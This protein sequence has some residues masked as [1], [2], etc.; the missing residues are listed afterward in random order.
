MAATIESPRPVPF[1]AGSVGAEPVERLGERVDVVLGEDSASVLDDEEG[2]GSV[3]RGRDADPT[4]RRVVGDRIFDHVLDHARQQCLAAAYA[5]IGHRSRS[6]LSWVWEMAFEQCSIAAAATSSS[7][8][9]DSS[10]R[11][12]CC[13]RARTRKLS[14]SRST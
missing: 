9:I 5:G 2:E 3:D 14:S 8:T 4:A 7:E 11:G 6:T 1:L 12:A 10:G 13:A